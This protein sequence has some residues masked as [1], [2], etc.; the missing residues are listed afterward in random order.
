VRKTLC[1]IIGVWLAAWAESSLA[2]ANFGYALTNA[3]PNLTFTNPLCLVTP[4]GETNRLFIV[5]KKGRIVVITN[6]A[7][8]TRTIF[9]DISSSSSVISA[10]D[11][12]IGGEEG[13]LGLAFHPGYVSNRYFYVFY[14][15]TATTTAGSG[16]HDILSRF[17]SSATNPNQGNAGSEL[18]LIVQ[19]DQADNHNAGDL[20]FGADGYLYVSLGDE[21]GSYGQYGN[22]QRIDHD[23][24]SGIMRLDVDLKPGSL[25]PNAHASALPSLTN[26][27]IPTDNPYVG[28][29]NFNGST[30]NS[31]NVRTE[32]WAVGM[33]NPWRFTFD[34]PTGALY[35]GHVGQGQVEWVN[36]VTKGANCGW[37]Y[38]EG[39]K[40]WTN[41]APSGF[42]FIPPLTQ[43]GHTNSRN[44]IIGGVVYHGARIP[45]L[46]G[47]YLYA[48][49]TS[50][51]IWALR[52]SGTNLTQNSIIL[53]NAAAKPNAF[54]L[55]PANGDVLIAAAR[56]GINSTIERL[57]YVQ[58][59]PR[60]TQISL[61][62]PNVVLRGTNGG[63]NQTYYLLAATNIAVPQSNWAAMA[64]GS[65]DAAGNF[66]LTSSV[67]P[68]VGQRFYR[69][70][71]P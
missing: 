45:L 24:F 23:F 19:Y 53:T 70:L 37:N 3:F 28:A 50:G 40:Q 26:Y 33:R 36:I 4:P 62:P 58:P 46:E 1:F 20:H 34:P 43:Y 8:P 7:A 30:V 35:L 47:A 16:R 11:T 13:L 66:T 10:A 6:L 29:T 69:L 48:D 17:Q 60:F 21:G 42:S 54:G 55:D 51:E 31:N 65:F 71:V 5:E 18:R 12:P 64:T 15:G 22:S 38:Y 32:F 25:T 41:P 44:C 27:A 68:S 14:T 56:G 49:H 57:V 39:G 59:I 2:A 67:A 9:M 52:N 61:A 63:F